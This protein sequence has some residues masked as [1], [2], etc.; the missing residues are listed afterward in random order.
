MVFQRELRKR[1]RSN[2][3]FN[4][5]GLCETVM[6]GQER[7]VINKGLNVKVITSMFLGTL[8]FIVIRWVLSD[9]SLNLKNEREILWEI[10]VKCIVEKGPLSI[11]GVERNRK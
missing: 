8:N 11:K 7:G 10:F 9:F 4:Y 6:H 5:K 2:L 3:M 1:V